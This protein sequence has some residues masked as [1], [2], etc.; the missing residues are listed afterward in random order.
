VDNP[1]YWPPGTRDTI[2]ETYRGS[3]GVAQGIYVYY[4]LVL[5]LSESILFTTL[6]WALLHTTL[7]SYYILYES[8]VVPEPCELA[9]GTALLLSGTGV[10]MGTVYTGRGSLG[11]YHWGLGLGVTGVWVF[12]VIQGGEFGILGVYTNDSYTGSTGISLEGLHLIHVLLGLVPVGVSSGTG[13]CM[14]I[15]PIDTIPMDTYSIMDYSY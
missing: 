7:S 6:S 1:L 14:D 5:M 9:Y 2:R 12:M 13:Y 15:T 8:L 11:V 4:L 10:S 3:T